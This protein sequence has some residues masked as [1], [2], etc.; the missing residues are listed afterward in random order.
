MVPVVAVKEATLLIPVY[1]IV[2]RIQIQNDLPRC[3]PMGLE[4]HVH[5]QPIYRRFVPADLLGRVL[6]RTLGRQFQSVQRAL[7]RQG[8]TSISSLFP[9]PALRI[10]L[11]HH[12]RQHRIRS[13]LIVV[14]QI[15]IAQTQSVHPLR[16]QLFDPVFHK[17]RVPTIP[18]TFGKL[19]QDPG[20][21]FRFS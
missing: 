10:G 11:T 18:E 13:E 12:H 8:L 9:C 6:C 19:F 3:P 20:P 21:F 16:H 4:E 5:H 14:V 17:S 2:G 7:A 1:Q 15:F